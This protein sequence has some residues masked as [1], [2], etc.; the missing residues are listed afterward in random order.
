[1]TMFTQVPTIE[2]MKELTR[3]NLE[4]LKTQ[5]V[6]AKAAGGQVDRNVYIV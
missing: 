1:M 3:S 4:R 2:L 5:I 6:A